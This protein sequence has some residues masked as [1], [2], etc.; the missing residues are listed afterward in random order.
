MMTDVF[1]DLFS[2]DLVA[3]CLAIVAIVWV[4]RKA[5]ET[6]IP[7]IVDKTFWKGFLVP[8]MPVMIGGGGAVVL[9]KYPFPDTFGIYWGSRLVFGLFAGFIS[10]W[11][12]LIIKK[13]FLDKIGTTVNK[14]SS[15][16]DDKNTPTIP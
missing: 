9:N 7:K 8:S 16:I 14:D 13:T 15:T 10:G 5:V 6:N 1:T 3:F 11:V 2:F 12:Y 4:I